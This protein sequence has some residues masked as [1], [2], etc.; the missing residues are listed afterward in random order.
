MATGRCPFGGMFFLW[1]P[2]EWFH[3]TG[4]FLPIKASSVP[5]FLDRSSTS[6]SFRNDR[7]LCDEVVWLCSA[8]QGRLLLQQARAGTSHKASGL[9][10]E[11]EFRLGK[12]R[13]ITRSAVP[14]HLLGKEIAM[15]KQ[16]A[17]VGMMEA[18][19][20]RR[21]V[22]AYTP[23]RLD[24]ATIRSLLAAAVRAPRSEE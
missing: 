20:G 3:F 12:S 5:R 2:K 21:S 16:E 10:R 7:G 8:P 11:R 24:E 14:L 17:P 4:R 19:Y 13:R 6:R 1:K 23:Q 22:R 9:A 15:T 18:I